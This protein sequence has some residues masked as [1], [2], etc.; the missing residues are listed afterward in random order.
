VV[1]NKDITAGAVED[2]PLVDS[3][4]SGSPNE[5][6]SVAAVKTYVDD[7]KELEVI[8]KIKN[9]K[10]AG[11]SIYQITSWLNDNGYKTKTGKEFTQVQVKRALEK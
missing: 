2:I 10:R 5:I 3:L 6:P 4:A 11:K 8:K 1:G 9:H 7:P